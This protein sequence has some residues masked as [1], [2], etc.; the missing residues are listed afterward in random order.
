MNSDS[1]LDDVIIGAGP[2]AGTFHKQP[3]SRRDLTLFS[4]FDTTNKNGKPHPS[5]HVVRPDE[6]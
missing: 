3:G 4:W 6:T 1:I 2:N 5:L